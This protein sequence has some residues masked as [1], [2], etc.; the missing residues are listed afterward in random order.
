MI[1]TSE[2]NWY[3]WNYDGVPFAR[4]TGNQKFSTTFSAP[5]AGYGSFKEEMKRAAASTLDVYSGLKPS[6]LFSGG[7]DSEI[8]LRSYLEIGS[9]PNVYIF[10]YEN[11][12]NI[13][14]VSYAVTICSILNVDYKIIDFNLKQFYENDAE[15]YSELAQIDRPR[16][17][18]YCKF[19]E[20]VDGFPILGTS[21]LTVARL[22]ADYSVKGDW[23]VRCWE[24][25]IGWSK[26]IRE[27]NK[28]AV[29]EWFK[30]SP[31]LVASFL[32]LNWLQDLVNDRIP[33]KLGTNSSKIVGYREAYPDLL[34]RVKKTGF[35][36]LNNELVEEFEKF[37]EK[38]NGGLKYRNGYDRSVSELGRI[39]NLTV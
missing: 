18:P 2:N 20:M 4:Q 30:W 34:H 25:D 17:L 22:S 36:N 23:I 38:K 28:P 14:D 32:K 11:D 21:D 24:H 19:L 7:Q 9:V 3:S 12:C 35:E 39:F 16:A 31:G 10:R 29:A 6:I 37:L 26:F 1:Y 13:Y 8:M 33:G 27:I 5:Q 15:R